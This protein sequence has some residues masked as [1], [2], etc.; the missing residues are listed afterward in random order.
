MN[1]ILS[2]FLREMKIYMERP[3][4][5][6]EFYSDKSTI[7]NLYGSLFPKRDLDYRMG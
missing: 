7:R 1:Y 6:N 5:F 2:I 4:L 3:L